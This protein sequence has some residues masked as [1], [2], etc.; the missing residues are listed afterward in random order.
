MTQEQWERL[1]A[2]LSG[3][4]VEPLPVG[5]IIDSPWLPNWAGM[6][7]LDYFAD[8]EHW[9]NANKQANDRFPEVMFL[10]GYWAEFGMC[11]EPASFGAK[12]LFYENEFPFAQS[13]AHAPAGVTQPNPRTDGLTPFI[14][15]RL[16]LLRSRIEAEDHVIRFAVARGPLNIAAFLMGSSEFLML[17]RMDP[18]GAHRLLGV[19]SAFLVDWLQLQ[20]T[21]IDSIDGILLLDD[22]VGFLGEQDFLEYAKPYL[23]QTFAA[24]GASVRFF[25]ND[26]H[27]LVCA[28]H[29]AD[30][31]VN[32]FNFGYEH[33]MNEMRRLVG[34]NV[35]LLGNIPPRDVLAV[36]SPENVAVCTREL[37]RSLEDR[38]RVILSC[39]GGMPPGVASQ[40]LDAFLAAARE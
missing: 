3:H 39:G 1:L 29:L 31:G 25:H 5:F 4:L 14:I 27:G 9:F 16:E 22:I 26:A 34:P 36:A 12:C 2:V 32:L 11:S 20:K 19:I 15:K 21:R 7:I 28:P 38:R 24:F 35:T 17:L 10:P 8:S 13:M 37:V 33:P 18:D 40:N 23:R 6:S 30:I